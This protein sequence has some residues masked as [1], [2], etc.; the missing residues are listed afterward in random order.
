MNSNI[1]LSRLHFNVYAICIIPQKMTREFHPTLISLTQE[2]W[3]FDKFLMTC[4]SQVYKNIHMRSNK[5]TVRFKRPQVLN[6]SLYAVNVQYCTLMCIRNLPGRQ[7]VAG[8]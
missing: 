2:N 1:Y 4:L 8:D 6:L 3:V 7:S 5:Y